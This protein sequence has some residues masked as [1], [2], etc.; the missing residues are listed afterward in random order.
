LG[1]WI[2]ADAD[3]GLTFTDDGAAIAI[4]HPRAAPTFT[5][6]GWVLDRSEL[7]LIGGDGAVLALV[8]AEVGG[9]LL[10][11]SVLPQFQGGA[12]YAGVYARDEGDAPTPLSFPER[13]T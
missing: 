3:L 4:G 1:H 13:S 6:V 12:A 7:S 10:V 8:G 5:T 9:E 11:L 2:C